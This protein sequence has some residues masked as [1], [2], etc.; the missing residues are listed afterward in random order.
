MINNYIPTTIIQNREA[1]QIE[2]A[3]VRQ[4]IHEIEFSAQNFYGTLVNLSRNISPDNYEAQSNYFSLLIKY[5]ESVKNLENHRMI[6][7]KLLMFYNSSESPERERIPSKIKAEI[8]HYYQMGRYNQT[9]LSEIYGIS[10]SSIS[11]IINNYGSDTK[12]N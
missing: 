11:K 2:I 3:R 7:Q 12:K 6:L 1:L 4:L 8:Y 10:Q 9:Q 5:N